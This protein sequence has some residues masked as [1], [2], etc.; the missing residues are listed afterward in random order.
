MELFVGDDWAED[1]H[2]VAVADAAGRR[3]VR[4]RLPEGVAGVARLHELVAEHLGE[5]PPERVTVGIETDRAPWVAALVAAGYRVFAVNPLSVARYRQ[6]H[7]T[8]GAKSDAGDAWLLA[9][10]VRTDADRHR[11]VAGDSAQVEALKVLARAHQTLIWERTRT[12]QRLRAT[13]REFFPA[14]LAAFDDLTAPDALELLRRAPDPA[15]AARLSVAQISAALRRARRRDVPAK[16]A[17]IQAV[18]RSEQLAQSAELA[19]AYAVTVTSLVALVEAFTAQVA[20]VE[21]SM[22]AC[23]H[24][25]SHAAIYLSQ[26]GLAVVLGSRLLG[27]FGDDPDRYADARARKNYAGTSP[28]TRASGKKT[29][30]VARYA[31]NT[32]IADSVQRWAQASL[33]ASPGARAY[34]DQL[35]GRGTGHQAA[36]RQLGNRLV[37]ILHGCLR[38]GVCYDEHTAWAPPLRDTGGAR[39][40]TRQTQGCLCGPA[41]QVKRTGRSPARW[42]RG[43]RRGARRARTL[44]PTALVCG[45]IRTYS[46]GRGGGA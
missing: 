27:E 16:A 34:Y 2:D 7:S 5:D 8:S 41:G 22:G 46:P 39:R 33:V 36:L 1:H 25:H 23:F 13:L 30:V 24:R 29:V 20:A 9:D 14:A 42:A 43:P 26:P 21:A 40:L 18:L 32:R 38:H 15:R 10:L 11:P 4:A 12:L 17:A 3:L 37:G 44:A 35:R 6:R 45:A 19:G 31:R 28:I